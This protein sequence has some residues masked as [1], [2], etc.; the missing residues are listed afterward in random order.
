MWG[1]KVGFCR[2]VWVG[3]ID[4]GIEGFIWPPSKD[5]PGFFLCGLLFVLDLGLGVSLD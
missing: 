4:D 5:G 3:L 1:R 2:Y